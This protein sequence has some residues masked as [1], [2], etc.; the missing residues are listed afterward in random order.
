M[1]HC[2]ESPL[3][4]KLDEYEYADFIWPSALWLAEYIF[5]HRNECQNKSVL[6]IGCGTG[7]VG[8]VAHALGA[9]CVLFTDRVQT[10]LLPPN[11]AC[12]WK[13][14]DWTNVASIE[15]FLNTDIDFHLDL[16]LS[17]DVFYQNDAFEDCIAT[18]SML[19]HRYPQAKLI[20][21]YQKR[22]QK[23]WKSTTWALP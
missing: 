10:V 11:S 6:E 5:H 3:Q 19:L 7:L 8:L 12:N 14:M 4:N 20:T 13:I 23:V 9:K 17:S 21:C 22:S 1:A 2:C 18:I 16:V 15:Q